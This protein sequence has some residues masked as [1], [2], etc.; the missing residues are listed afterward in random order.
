MLPTQ[1]SEPIE[2]QF[3]ESEH[4]QLIECTSIN[5]LLDISA[6]SKVES[7]SGQFVSPIFVVPKQDGSGRFIINLKKLNEF[8]VYQHFKMEDYR[9]VLSLLSA[10]SFMAKIDLQDAF[11]LVSIAAEHRKFLRF[12]FCGVL[13][14]F[15]CLP[16]GLSPA[17][18]IYTKIL[19]PVLAYLRQKGF[20]NANYL[21]DFLL[22]GISNR[23]LT[24]NIFVTVNLLTKLG[25]VVNYRK[26]VLVPKQE[27]EY[28]GLV[29]N[30]RDMTICLPQRKKDKI[31]KLIAKSLLLVSNSIEDISSLIGNL[32]AAVPAVQYS[33]I[34]TRYLE[35]DKTAALVKCNGNYADSM[36]LSVAS[37]VDLKWWQTVLPEAY[38]SIKKDSFDF[39]ITTDASR[40][41]WG[42]SV[43]SKVT[44]G[45]WST[46]ETELHI[47]TLELIAVYNALCSFFA[48]CQEIQ[49]LIKT[50]STTG[51]AYINRQGGCHS[52]PNLEIAHKIWS[53]CESRNIWI[54]A[55]YISSKA[56]FIAD[57]ASREQID[58]NDFGLD[59]N[60]F[61]LI[62]S[63]FGKPSIDLFASCHTFKCPRY[64]SWFPD[65]GSIC[66]D[67]FTVEWKEFF[68]AFP[69]FSLIPRV[70]KKIQNDR[71]RGILVV[72]NWKSQ[73]WF[74]IFMKLSNSKIITLKPKKFS[75]ICPFNRQTHPLSK[76]LSLLVAVLSGT[77]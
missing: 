6:I 44:R 10:D 52:L 12:K 31:L 69:P 22:L 63:K 17:P 35:L 3:S 34:H 76:T 60:S 72:P 48:E 70:L 11:Y 38:N 77:K 7:C 54:F 9:T 26:S 25:F 37:K 64:I 5:H 15:N 43:M 2:K 14:E 73:A 53:W 71:S 49:I 1:I 39:I 57:K 62:C 20:I 27:I 29:F 68:Y 16:F 47:N 66:A 40:T 8:I 23:D 51:I 36:K 45:F 75:L 13:Y 58:T 74:P 19:R 61:Q 46:E 30:S 4:K 18:R 67:A 50:D 21:D 24:K 33:M 55:T 41:G 28:L 59:G 32:I 65:P 42:A 56:N